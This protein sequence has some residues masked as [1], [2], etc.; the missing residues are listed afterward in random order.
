MFTLSVNGSE[1]AAD[2]LVLFL[3]LLNVSSNTFI[4]LLVEVFYRP[5]DI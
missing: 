3:F 4:R 2:L 5:G 1:S